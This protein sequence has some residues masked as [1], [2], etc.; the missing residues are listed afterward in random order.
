MNGRCAQIAARRFVCLWQKTP[1]FIPTHV[2]KSRGGAQMANKTC[3]SKIIPM[4]LIF[5]FVLAFPFI[6]FGQSYKMT[7]KITGIDLNHQTI[8]IE[9]PLGSQMFTVGG[10]LAPDVRLTRAD[11]PVKLKDFHVDEIVTVVFHSTD[12]GHVIDR[13]I[14]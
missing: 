13:I 9:V 12:Q 3:F 14:G 11:K 7:G 4:V 6:V 10:P 8:V 5:I 2:R 1:D